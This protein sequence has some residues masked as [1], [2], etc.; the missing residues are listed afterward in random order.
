M[1]AGAK[2]RPPR[3]VGVEKKSGRRALREMSRK[4]SMA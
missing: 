2:P 3:E 1:E 4:D